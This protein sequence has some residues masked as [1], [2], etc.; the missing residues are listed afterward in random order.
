MH[1][2]LKSSKL[3][4]LQKVDTKFPTLRKKL[5]LIIALLCAVARG[6]WA[7]ERGDFHIL[8]SETINGCVRKAINVAA[9]VYVLRLVDG[10]E[11]RTQ[12]I[13]ME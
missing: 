7:G 10:K 9:G 3:Y 2:L 6:A 8:S 13:V 11:V 1:F 12:K 5:L 4:Q